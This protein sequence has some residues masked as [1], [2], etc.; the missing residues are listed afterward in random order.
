VHKPFTGN[1]FYLIGVAEQYVPYAMGA[2]TINILNNSGYSIAAP[3]DAVVE[4]IGDIEKP[5]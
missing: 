3:T 5:K 2:P 1:E 4:M